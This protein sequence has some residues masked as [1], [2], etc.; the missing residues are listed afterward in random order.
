MAR[1]ARSTPMLLV[2][3]F[4][5]SG[6]PVPAVA[7]ADPVSSS[8]EPR[9][10]SAPV[11]RIAYFVPKDREPIPGYPQRLD[12]VV[13]E[14]Q[15]FYRKGMELNGHGPL[16]FTPDR[17]KNGGLR[18]HVVRA[19]SPMH[20]YGRNDSDKVRR[21]VKAAMAKDGVDIDRETVLIFQ[22]LLEWQGQKAVEVGPYVGGGDHRSGTAWVYDDERL[23]P[24]KLGDRSPG[25]YYGR[26]CSIGEF[27]SHYIGGIA[28][29]LGHALGLPHDREAKDDP[30]G[31]S[32]M[33]GGN[34]TYGEDKRGEGRGT[35]LSAASALPLVAHPLFSGSRKGVSASPSCRLA[36][37]RAD[38]RDGK[39]DLTG[40]LT[41]SPSAYGVVGYNDWAKIPDDYDALGATSPLDKDGRFHM[42][43]GELT[44][45]HWELRLGICHENGGRSALSF[46][47]DVDKDGKPDLSAFREAWLLGEAVKA[48]A[49]G[50]TREAETLAAKI[51][52]ATPEGSEIRRKAAHLRRLCRPEKPKNLASLAASTRQVAVTELAFSDS[53]VGWGRPLRDEVIVEG[54][55][56]CFLQIDGKFHESGLFAHA[57]SQY[58]L[59]LAKDWKRLKAGYGLQDGHDGSVV[60]VVRADG[61]ELFRSS[62]IKDHRLHDLDVD[63]SGAGTLELVTENGGDGASGD[64]GVWIEPRLER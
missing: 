10:G 48:R 38:Y 28:H 46:E 36:D 64:W 5:L 33:G 39:L 59:D 49:A 44:P 31:H 26:P 1:K 24:R 17:D 23:D 9:P 14:V 7:A 41:A 19:A 37:I 53:S 63:L 21:E 45:G 58:T 34:H 12:R 22:V 16:T 54:H 18:I 35:F 60:F 13:A 27:N 4:F 2:G 52:T 57:P 8:P 42:A 50:N 29:E 11:L 61:K 30:R 15:Q 56:T 51:E 6:G 47:Y 62:L 40:Q 20:D 32:L 55:P 3:L 25:G 43:F